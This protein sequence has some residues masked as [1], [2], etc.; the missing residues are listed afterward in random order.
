M[1]VLCI[2]FF[3]FVDMIICLEYVGFVYSLIDDFIFKYVDFVVC[4]G[5][6][7]VLIG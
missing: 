7:V 1:N 5:D 2:C 4:F 6:C 3:V